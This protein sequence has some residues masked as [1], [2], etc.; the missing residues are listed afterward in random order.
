MATTEGEATAAA[1][2]CMGWMTT[3]LAWL[4]TTVVGALVGPT[5]M[6]EPDGVCTVIVSVGGCGPAAAELD[7]DD[8]GAT[9]VE[10]MVRVEVLWIVVTTLVEVDGCA[11][12]EVDGC[13]AADEVEGCAAAD[14]VAG[15]GA[16]IVVVV[17]YGQG[18]P[19]GHDVTVLTDVTEVTAVLGPG[20]GV[21]EDTM[22]RAE[23][24]VERSGQFGWSG[25]QAVTVET[26]VEVRVSVL[27][28]GLV[29][30]TM[31]AAEVLIEVL[32]ERSG[33]LGSSG[34]HVVMVETWVDVRVSVLAPGLVVVTT[35]AAEVLVEVLVERSGQL[36]SSGGHVV[37]VETWVEVK[38][39]VLAPGLAVVVTI[40][41]AEVLVDSYGQSGTP[42]AQEWIVETWVVVKVSVLPLGLVVVLSVHD[43]VVV[44]V[45]VGYIGSQRSD[46]RQR[47]RATRVGGRSDGEGSAKSHELDEALH[48]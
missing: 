21:V 16:G 26:W 19:A 45:V 39:S 15:G 2:L 9:T 35:G 38:V 42:G 8:A 4:A 40:G 11:A 37:M 14:E 34:G 33:Q 29:V 30:V 13:A 44:E 25:G 32:V 22:G 41:A 10:T 7:G 20:A 5:R 6:T 28:P 23:V 48:L 31:G 1:E 46:R 43:V 47:D 12:A 18:T 36:G 24:L 17:T 27:A 3:V